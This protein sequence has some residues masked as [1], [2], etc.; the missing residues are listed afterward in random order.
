MSLGALN[1]LNRESR[2]MP[3]LKPAVMQL[4]QEIAKAC[5]NCGSVHSS[6][7]YEEKLLGHC[8]ADCI[9]SMQVNTHSTCSQIRVQRIFEL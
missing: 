6:S 3:A 7:S 2:A 5:R 1:A 9:A 4:K 8:V